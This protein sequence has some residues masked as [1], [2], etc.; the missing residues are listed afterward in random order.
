MVLII[1]VGF[2]I[3]LL[4]GRVLISFLEDVDVVPIVFDGSWRIFTHL[5][6]PVFIVWNLICN[7]GDY[8]SDNL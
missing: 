4:V 3:Y 7:L 2:I 6:W 1:I 8:I 5:L